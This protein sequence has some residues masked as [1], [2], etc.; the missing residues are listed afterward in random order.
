MG[1]KAAALPFGQHTGPPSPLPPSEAP[2]NGQECFAKERDQ[3][4]AVLCAAALCSGDRAAPRA[5][6]GPPTEPQAGSGASPG[7]TLS[8]GNKDL[9]PLEELPKRLG[10]EDSGLGGARGWVSS[11]SSSSPPSASRQ[12]TP[13]G[14]SP[15]E[16]DSAVLAE[17]VAANAAFPPKNLAG[18]EDKS[19]PH[20]PT[21]TEVPRVEVPVPG[22]PKATLTETGDAGG[23]QPEPEDDFPEVAEKGLGGAWQGLGCGGPAPEA[24]EA[25]RKASSLRRLEGSKGERPREAPKARPP[26]AKRRKGAPSACDVCCVLFKSKLGLMRHKAV[27]HLKANVGSLSLDRDLAS[28]EEPSEPSKAL[29]R[30]TRTPSVDEEEASRSHLAKAATSRPFPK[31]YRGP[32]REPNREMQEVVSKVLGDLSAISSAIS[33]KLKRRDGPHQERRAQLTSSWADRAEE[34]EAPCSP[35][36]AKAGG[37]GGGRGASSESFAGRKPKG[38][39]RKGKGKVAAGPQEAPRH[40]S[41]TP[42]PSTHPDVTH[43]SLDPVVTTGLEGEEAGPTCSTED[44]ARDWTPPWPLGPLA[45]NGSGGAPGRRPSTDRTP[46]PPGP[47]WDDRGGQ[48]QAGE[49]VGKG[50]WSTPDRWPRASTEATEEGGKNGACGEQEHDPMVEGSPGERRPARAPDHLLGSLLGES[51]PK[52]SASGKAMET[53]RPP[54]VEAEPQRMEERP[55]EMEPHRGS[56]VAANLHSLFDDDPS[57]SQLFPRKDHFDARRKC[58][59]VYGKR[60]K[61]LRPVAEA[62]ACLEGPTDPLGVR[63]ASDLGDTGSLGVTREDPFEYDT[64]STD[65]TLL[66]HM[67]HGGGSHAGATEVGSRSAERTAWPPEVEPREGGADAEE[68][69]QVPFL[70]PKSP[71]GSLQGFRGQSSPE[72]KA[73]GVSSLGKERLSPPQAFPAGPSAD[74]ATEA[75]ELEGGALESRAEQNLPSPA[76]NTSGTEMLAVTIDTRDLCPCGAGEDPLSQAGDDGSREPPALPGRATKSKLEEGK[77]GKARGD[78]T[79]KGKEKPY[80]CKVCFQWFLTLG[81][82][83]FHKLSHNPSPP[84]TCYMCVQRRFSSREQLRDHLREKHARNKAGLW[85]CG[86]CLKEVPGVWMYNEHLREHATQFAR[87][88]QAQASALGLPGGCCFGQDEAAVSRF[89]CSLLRQRPSRAPR[90]PGAGGR[91]PPTGQESPGQKGPPGPGGGLS[92]E[93]PEAPPGTQPPAASPQTASSSPEPAPKVDG[94][95]K[96]AQAMHPECK[97][98]SRDCHHCGKQFPKPFKLQRHLVVHS[99]QKIY[100]C[101]LCPTFYPETQELRHHLGQEHRAAEAMEL[102]HTTLYACELCADVM[103]VI[104]K[105]FICSACNYTFSKKEQYDRHM[106][107]H[108]VGGSRTFR[109]RGVMRPGAA[110]GK[111][112]GKKTKEE[113]PPGEGGMPAAKRKKVAHS[114]AGSDG[115][116]EAPLEGEPPAPLGRPPAAPGRPTAP[117]QDPVKTEELEGGFCSLL[118]EMPESP[119]GSL[120]PLPLPLGGRIK[121]SRAWPCLCRAAVRRPPPGGESAAL[122]RPSGG[123]IRCGSCP[124]NLYKNS[125]PSLCGPK[126]TPSPPPREAQQGTKRSRGEI[127]EQQQQPR[128]PCPGALGQ[129]GLRGRPGEQN[130]GASWGQRWGQRGETQGI[131]GPPPPEEA[132]PPERAAKL[133]CPDA[134]FQVLPLKDKAPLPALPRLA[135]EVPPKKSTRALGALA[136]VPPCGAAQDLPASCGPD[137]G[138]QEA[139]SLPLQPIGGS[140]RGEAGRGPARAN[141]A[142]PGRCPER[143][144][145]SLV[146]KPHPRKG[147]SARRLP[148]AGRLPVRTLKKDT[149]AAAERRCPGA[150]SQAGTRVPEG[151]RG[152][153]GPAGKVWPS[154]PGGGTLPPPS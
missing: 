105:S 12:N 25:E 118:S 63:M 40:P 84:P 11:S 56:S 32:R 117:S 39:A 38:K 26:R 19:C 20:P 79:L 6:T 133:P 44:L 15:S 64:L 58:A 47:L 123:R 128:G 24:A 146:A 107:K 111:E 149:A 90:Q 30:K 153:A 143:P 70:E 112:A 121:G 3:H 74:E 22:T 127:L 98:P 31:S 57:F 77:A 17:G 141:T 43:N 140:S 1:Q 82:L 103:H 96:L 85:A 18:K 129:P 136:E 68:E 97:D 134:A 139:G 94:A 34:E 108:L 100:L 46:E 115:N 4:L 71:A 148:R 23:A 89:L 80:K 110:P 51:L 135:R 13:H 83:D 147:K 132:Q 29:P 125:L 61:K 41:E 28:P 78:L 55:P 151:P 144:V 5:G 76:F 14:P 142:E 52:S 42:L 126:G 109:F 95:P 131:A 101:P 69:R 104:K 120:P 53:T 75:P 16:A 116:Q 36:E 7:A 33:H 27:K 114:L 88:G 102:K 54:P 154:P 93:S 150:R 99:F 60:P 106:E 45:L 9:P 49:L 21:Q 87:R 130:P 122:F 8:F 62:K 72:R 91:A 66:L 152:P 113:A 48:G 124:L 137:A 37:G 73:G 2:A 119:P 92:R 50:P 81:E 67:S 10:D 145:A 86:M 59:R 35:V 65:D 138:A